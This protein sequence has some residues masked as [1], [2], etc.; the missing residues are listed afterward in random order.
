MQPDPMLRLL[1]R[2]AAVFVG[3]ALI[4]PTIVRALALPAW[5]VPLV[6]SLL[7]LGMPIAAAAIWLLE[8]RR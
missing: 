8:R 4:A 1:A 6:L 5:V 7:V 2:Y 3:V